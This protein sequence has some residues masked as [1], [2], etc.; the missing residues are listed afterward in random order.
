MKKIGQKIQTQSADVIALVG[1]YELKVPT[2]CTMQ[3]L[4]IQT[5]FP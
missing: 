5:E 4:K 1:W 3:H 2:Q